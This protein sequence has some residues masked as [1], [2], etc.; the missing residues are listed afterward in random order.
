MISTTDHT[1]FIKGVFPTVHHYPLKRWKP[2]IKTEKRK[3]MMKPYLYIH[4]YSK[5]S[6]FLPIPWNNQYYSS[7]ILPALSISTSAFNID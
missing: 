3:T 2:V 6:A 4:R 7:E 5:K 1:M